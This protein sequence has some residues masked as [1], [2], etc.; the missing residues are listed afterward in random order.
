ML[1]G[2]KSLYSKIITHNVNITPPI[3]LPIVPAIAAFE[4]N[5]FFRCVHVHKIY[6]DIGM[7]DAARMLNE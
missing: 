1:V 6:A 5:R 7:I 2:K 3:I 4:N